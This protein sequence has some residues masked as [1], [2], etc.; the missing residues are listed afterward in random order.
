VVLGPPAVIGDPLEVQSRLGGQRAAF[1]G[2]FPF[3]IA[4]ASIRFANL[5]SCSMLSR[6]TLLI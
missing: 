4:P 5:A 6:G 1:L 3:G 2:E